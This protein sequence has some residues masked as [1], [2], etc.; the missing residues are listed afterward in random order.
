VLRFARRLLDADE[1]TRQML[2][3]IDAG[4]CADIDRAV[5]LALSSPEPTADGVMDFVLAPPA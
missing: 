4:V 3:E 2:L 1:V 5:E